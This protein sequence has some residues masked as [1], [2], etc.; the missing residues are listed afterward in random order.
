MLKTIRSTGS[1]ANSKETEG[2]VGGNSVVGDM[3]GGNEAINLTKGKNQAKTT[4][5]KILVKFKNHDFPN[6]RTKEAGTG[7]FTSE[8][9]LAFIQLKQAFVKALILYYFD[10]E[11]H[12]RIE[13]NISSYI[14][15]GILSQLSSGT[16][17]DG[18]VT[19]ANL[20]Q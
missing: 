13:T 9:R 11:S 3:V 18:V 16:R 14:I 5:S 7:F 2:K 4:K 8:T 20:G 6:S 17:P 10:L 1:A 12:I 19:K 15:G